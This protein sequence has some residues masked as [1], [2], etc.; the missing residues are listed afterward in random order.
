MFGG[1]RIW[2]C[3]DYSP[4]LIFFLNRIQW[5]SVLPLLILFLK[6]LHVQDAHSHQKE[7]NEANIRAKLAISELA[8]LPYSIQ[9]SCAQLSW[10]QPLCLFLNIII[11][12]SYIRNLNGVS[13][14]GDKLDW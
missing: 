8:F 2:N 7:N 6:G 9:W 13:N 14:L 3:L 11:L 12:S 5:Y 4:Y 1:K 10:F